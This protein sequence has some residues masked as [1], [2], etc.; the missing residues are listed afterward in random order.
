MIRV[1]PRKIKSTSP[2]DEHAWFSEPIMKWGGNGKRVNISCSFTYDKP[3]AEYLAEAWSKAGYKVTIGGPA[4]DDFGG[5]FIPGMY[6]KKG[7]VITSRG[8][9]NSC[10]FCSVPKREGGIRELIIKDGHNILDSN[11]LQCSEDH[12]RNVF[13]MLQ[14][15]KEKATF[16]G[17]LEAKIL[18]DWHIDLLVNLKPKRFY[19]AYDTPDD[20]EPLVL[21]AK[22]IRDAGF[23]YWQVS[24]Y[25]LIGF[26]R[27]R[28]D[29]AE[30][31]L[32]S[33]C[34]LGIMPF[35]MLWRGEDGKY[36]LTWK[37]FQREWASPTIV[38][39]KMRIYQKAR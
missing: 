25:V 36:D 5:E 11:L 4:Y 12:I 6:L 31:R 9:N 27:D 19:F 2:D 16:T 18:Q 29:L 37:R 30:Q 1:F 33:V 34:R 22:K 13:S 20:W 39:S 35:A 10:W 15:Q 38:G 24:C 17:G 3:R 32:R 26:P 8:C 28:M 7:N 23:K 21:A 14:H